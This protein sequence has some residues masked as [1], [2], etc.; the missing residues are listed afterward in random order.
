M[1]T[2]RFLTVALVLAAAALPAAVTADPPPTPV[3][4][5]VYRSFDSGKP[6]RDAGMV[7]G[8]IEDVD[9]GSGT[10]VVRTVKGRAMTVAVLPSTTIYE[11]DEYATLA[12][13]RRGATVEISVSE[14]GGKLVAQIIH[15][16]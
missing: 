14:V 13:L 4:N 5:G 6:A 9:Y 16:K 11:R 12:D 1:G 8:Q 7:R 10:I 2:I 15:L 3:P